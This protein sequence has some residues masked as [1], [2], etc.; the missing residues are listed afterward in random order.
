MLTFHPSCRYDE[1]FV[2]SDFVDWFVGVENL[3]ANRSQAVAVGQQL[4]DMKCVLMRL[5]S[6]SPPASTTPIQANL[7]ATHTSPL[8]KV[9]DHAC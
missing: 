6:M 7:G 9:C 1:C 5:T 3:K 4:L 2:A 8:L